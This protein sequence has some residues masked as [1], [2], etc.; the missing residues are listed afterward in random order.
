[1]NWSPFLEI[2]VGMFQLMG[3]ALGRFTAIR[4]WWIGLGIFLPVALGLMIAE[5]STQSR[6]WSLSGEDLS[7]YALLGGFA[8]VPALAT[9]ALGRYL[10][11]RGQS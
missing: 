6:G 5:Q 10:K 11:R 8:A 1:M 4:V 7:I 3:V 2:F 9:A